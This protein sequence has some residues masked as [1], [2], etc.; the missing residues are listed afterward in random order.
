MATGKATP[1]GT[2]RR[3]PTFANLLST[4][5]GSKPDGSSGR[6]T[7]QQRARQHQRARTAVPLPPQTCL[8]PDP[9]RTPM[10]HQADDGT[11]IGTATP[12]GTARRAPTSAN[13]L[14]PDPDRTPM[15]HQ[16]DDGTAR[17]WARLA[18]PLPSKTCLRPDQNRT[19]MVHQAE[20][21]HVNG[22]GPST[23][24]AR[25]APTSANL[26]AARHGSNPDGSSGR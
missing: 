20:A 26:L 17:Q 22:H 19:P 14:R 13:L 16:A 21:R 24:T 1:T 8:R 11:S 9:D 5:H 10:A 23:G 4:R 18:V 6:G 25:R 7:A 3:A 12:S 15:V 2:A